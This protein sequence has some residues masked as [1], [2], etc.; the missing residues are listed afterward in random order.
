MLIGFPL[1]GL[2]VQDCFLLVADDGID[3]ELTS[4]RITVE[5]AREICMQMVT[6]MSL[7]YFSH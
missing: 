7:R 6:S 4:K 3:S 5:G 2:P 1:P